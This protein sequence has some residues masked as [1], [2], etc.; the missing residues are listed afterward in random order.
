MLIQDTLRVSSKQKIQP[1]ENRRLF[2]PW[3]TDYTKLKTQFH[4]MNMQNW[5]DELLKLGKESLQ[6]KTDVDSSSMM[7]SL[8]EF[9]AYI[10][11]NYISGI[12]LLTD[13]FS[14]LFKMPKASTLQESQ[15]RI[16]EALNVLRIIKKRQNCGSGWLKIMLTKLYTQL[17]PRRIKGN[18]SANA[19][20]S[21][22]RR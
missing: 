19:P 11:A 8:Q 22:L 15:K 5:Q 18:L 4:E 3:Q 12:N 21:K 16:N 10:R 2:L 20:K 7:T 14:E 13:L 17:S 6:M 9:E 1:L